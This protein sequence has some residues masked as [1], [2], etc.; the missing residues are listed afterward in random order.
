MSYVELC[1]YLDVV[2]DCIQEK[3]EKTGSWAAWQ[4]K[5]M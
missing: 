1:K 3:L 4:L 2:E 5:E